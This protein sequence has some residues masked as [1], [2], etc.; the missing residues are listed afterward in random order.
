MS[1]KI[2]CSEC[3]KKLVAPDKARGKALKCPGCGAR[4]KVPAGEPAPKPPRKKVS[5]K[6]RKP[7]PKPKVEAAPDSEDFLSTLDLD[8]LEHDEFQICPKCNAHVSTEEEECPKCGF[9][10]ALG[11]IQ[12]KRFDD[13]PKVTD[14]A[15]FYSEALSDGI[16]FTKSTMSLVHKGWAIFFVCGLLMIWMV[17][18]GVWCATLPPKIFW[19]FTTVVTFIVALGWVWHQH[20]EVLAHTNKSKK[21]IEKV[22][23]DFAHCAAEGVKGILWFVAYS[24][25]FLL[26]FGGIAV[27]L[28]FLGMYELQLTIPIAIGVTFLCISTVFPQALSHMKMPIQYRGWLIHETLKTLK[29]TFVPGLYWWLMMIVSHMIWIGLFVGLIFIARGPVEDFITDVQ[30][31]SSIRKAYLSTQVLT[32]TQAEREAK[33]AASELAN[34]DPVELSWIPQAILAGGWLVSS[35]FLSIA[36]VFNA[37]TNGLFMRVLKRDLN[38]VMHGK[39]NVYVKKNVE[40]PVMTLRQSTPAP[41]SLRVLAGL[42]DGLIIL[43]ICAV[44]TG[45]TMYFALQL[46]GNSETEFLRLI[47]A[48][49]TLTVPIVA[50]SLSFVGIL[51]FFMI[52]D[53]GVSQGTIGKTSLKL[54]ITNEKG[55]R[56][57]A[58]QA[59]G[60]ILM[61]II[62]LS[63]IATSIAVM[64]REDGRAVH[65]L[66]AGTKVRLQKPPRPPKK[67]EGDE[68]E[69]E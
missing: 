7:A 45:A 2:K 20:V 26:L 51:L 41:L 68:E 59:I 57:G 33:E 49:E 23:F 19:G 58:G 35:F 52:S 5:P 56:I 27:G 64:F 54:F 15:P 53:S 31:N 47:T 12:A 21:P 66:A 4:I 62:T 65:D 11:T 25:P 3:E 29:V 43:L 28:W 36:T 9:E 34:E 24:Y 32:D 44:M 6:K 39:E 8:D 69:E 60:R 42:I 38:L 13:I 50:A 16:E 22:R 63:P 61:Q 1:I 37:R 67:K 46:Y 18:T 17:I 14:V 40:K 55:K 30:Y 48:P 10:V